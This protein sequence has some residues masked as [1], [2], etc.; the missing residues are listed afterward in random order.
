MIL[1]P[2]NSN[3]SANPRVA[4]KSINT[5]L[6]NF[7]SRN[8]S[9][10]LVNIF[11]NVAQTVQTCSDLTT[12]LSFTSEIAF[13]IDASFIFLTIVQI[14]IRTF[15]DIVAPPVV[16][17]RLESFSTTFCAVGS[18]ML[19]RLRNLAI[20][21]VFGM[22]FSARK[23]IFRPKIHSKNLKNDQIGGSRTNIFERS[24]ASTHLKLPSRL[25]HFWVI[26]EKTRWERL[27]FGN[28]RFWFSK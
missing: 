17:I 10:T 25:T 22:K 24:V 1:T 2:W 12:D 16:F 18:K 6:A 5:S 7:A 8:S 19:V 3:F 9:S 13:N 20:F 27:D 11:T 4:S 21:E 15:V 28:F 26:V 23:S 14:G